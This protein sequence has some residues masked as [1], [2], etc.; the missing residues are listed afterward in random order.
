MKSLLF[1]ALFLLISCEST[2]SKDIVAFYKCLLLDSDVVYNHINSFVEAIKTLDPIKFAESFSTIYA[3]I[4]S[5]VTRCELVVKLKKNNDD[6]VLRSTN[7]VENTNK[8]EGG[9]TMK[10]LFSALLKAFLSFI[11]PTLKTLGINI[12]DIC[13]KEFTD[14]FLCD[15]LE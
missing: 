2:E 3:A 14:S 15:L 4:S 1:I 7:E 10:A 6:I 13:Q 8:N 12:K 11:N 9:S 5:E